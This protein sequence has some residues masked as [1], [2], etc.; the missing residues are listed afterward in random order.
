MFII[1]NSGMADDG[2]TFVDVVG[3][4][5]TDLQEAKDEFYKFIT[6]TYFDGDD[7]I[8][9]DYRFDNEDGLFVDLQ[10]CIYM[11]S[12]DSYTH[13]ELKSFK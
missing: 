3:K 4:S 10:D 7:T 5:F 9:R 8:P 11:E 6:E 12:S 1:I 2:E 13:I